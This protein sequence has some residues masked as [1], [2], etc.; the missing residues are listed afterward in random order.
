M[1]K[2]MLISHM[3]VGC[4]VEG[5]VVSVGAVRAKEGKAVCGIRPRSHKVTKA[6]GFRGKTGKVIKRV[7]RNIFREVRYKGRGRWGH[8]LGI[9]CRIDSI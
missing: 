8:I 1:L 5:Y 3:R 9:G 7:G 4:K 6:K 2:S